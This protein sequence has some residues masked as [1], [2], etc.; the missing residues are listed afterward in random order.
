MIVNKNIAKLH[1]ITSPSD[2]H[3]TMDQIKQVVLGGCN[4]VQLRM[5]EADS[6]E[7][8]Q[9]A[10]QAL[11]FCMDNDAK[12]IIN[13]NVQLA[14]KIGADGVHL[15]KN[16]MLPSEARAI[17]GDHSIIGGTA[18][19]FEDIKQLVVQGVDYIGLGP[20]RFTETKK[21]LSPVLGIEGYQ[22]IISQC[23]ENNINLPIIAIGGLLPDD[24]KALFEAGVH[25]IAISS[26]L[27]KQTQPG[28][29]TLELL[30]NIG[31][32]SSANWIKK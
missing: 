21:K 10:L 5:K 1:F 16:D 11:S 31:K 17:L 2:Q 15:G 22:S 28:A 7:F 4:W 8:E 30:T 14:A 18:N 25:G 29:Q 6:K 12:L 32:Y 27:T 3:S 23:R 20:Y 13:D 26:Y 19:T 24:L 9:T